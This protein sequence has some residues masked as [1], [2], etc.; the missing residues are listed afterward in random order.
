MYKILLAGSNLLTKLKSD[1]A[2][3]Y[4]AEADTYV[5]LVVSLKLPFNTLLASPP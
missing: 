3:L 2:S 4:I 1:C 5:I